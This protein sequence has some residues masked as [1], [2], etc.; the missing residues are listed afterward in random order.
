MRLATIRTAD[1][2]RAVRIENEVAV[3]TGCTNLNELLRL[4]RWE[5]VAAEAEGPQHA[6]STLDYAPLV[7]D[8]SRVLCVGLNYRDHIREMGRDIPDFPTLFAKF[9]STLIGANDDIVIPR[10]TEALDWEAELGVVIGRATKH[11]SRDEAMAA[12][13]GYTV[14]NDITARDWQYRTP[15]W[16][17]GK[18]FE[19]TTPVGPWLLATGSQPLAL[20][21][22]V[23][24]CE[25]NGE[26][27]Q[28]AELSQLVFDPAHLVSYISGFV[29]LH[30][31]DLIAT[32][33]PGGVGHA[34]QP[35]RYLEHLTEVVTR[36]TGL[37]E[38]RNRCISEGDRQGQATRS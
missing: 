35:A 5:R 1:G 37:G 8:D 36:V 11:A 10:L 15:Q 19:S 4:P 2:T 22:H 21:D 25:V 28:S 20:K 24:S 32:G 18:N 14:V 34:R 38:C 3:E 26:L 27:M 13:A 30:P 17:Q 23:I 31:G 33:T 16:F 12:I 29:T 6:L 9:T 7:S